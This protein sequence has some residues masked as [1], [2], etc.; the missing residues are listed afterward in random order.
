[1]IFLLVTVSIPNRKVQFSLKKK[2]KFSEGKTKY[3]FSSL[4][5]GLDMHILIEYINTMTKIGG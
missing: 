3:I 1:M 5:L 4:M 2:T